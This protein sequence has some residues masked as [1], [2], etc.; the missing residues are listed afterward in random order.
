[1]ID[2]NYIIKFIKY[3]IKNFY[4][5]LLPMIIISLIG[6]QYRIKIQ[7]L[8]FYKTTIKLVCREDAETANSFSEISS[9]KSNLE[10]I[11]QRID[12]YD[13]D[14]LNSILNF[15]SSPLT[16]IISIN[17][18]H[19]DEN[20]SKSIAEVA[21]EVSVAN[22]KQVFNIADEK[23]AVIENETTTE[24]QDG[25]NK[26]ALMFLVLFGMLVG[27]GTDWLVFDLK[28]NRNNSKLNKKDA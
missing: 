13:V 12:S 6:Y 22:F 25:K 24:K 4:L 27:I 14:K 11:A 17:V 18:T 1:M 26:K 16:K 10:K 20:K 5:I 2:K 3:S 7:P 9:S 28:N 15:T 23:L 19:Y 8:A 21:K